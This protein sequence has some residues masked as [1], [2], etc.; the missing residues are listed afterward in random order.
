MHP[1]Q[2]NLSLPRSTSEIRRRQNLMQAIYDQRDINEVVLD[3]NANSNGKNE[4]AEDNE[5]QQDETLK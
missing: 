3:L 2:I 4:K 5:E 1:W